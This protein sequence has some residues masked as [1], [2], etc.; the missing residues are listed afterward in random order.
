M[1]ERAHPSNMTIL[2]RRLVN[3]LRGR[4]FSAEP[5]GAAMVWIGDREPT[6]AAA[7]RAILCRPDDDGH[8]G[9]WWRWFGRNGGLAREWLCAADEIG[10]AADEIARVLAAADERTE[11]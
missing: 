8:L 1:D 3:A 4:G 2:V 7:R 11:R 10:A 9:W 5:F 6:D